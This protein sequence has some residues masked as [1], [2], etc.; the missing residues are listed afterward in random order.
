LI[1]QASVKDDR[2]PPVNGRVR[3]QL[4][5]AGTLPPAVANTV[6]SATPLCLAEMVKCIRSFG[7]PP[8]CLLPPTNSP[9]ELLKVR[10]S[11]ESYDVQTAQFLLELKRLD[12][13]DEPARFR[14]GPKIYPNGARIVV[15]GDE[16]ADVS[17]EVASA[18]GWVLIMLTGE[19]V[20]ITVNRLDTKPANSDDEW[21]MESRQEKETVYVYNP[22]QK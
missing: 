18:G 2:L 14:M 10:M 19:S 12:V 21:M 5:C 16:T 20:L 9:L 6:A 1:L 13:M 7:I 4:H 8:K 15:K 3:A 17:F 11:K 22:R